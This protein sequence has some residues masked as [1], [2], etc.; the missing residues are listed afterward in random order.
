VFKLT[1]ASSEE[2]VASP[3][4]RSRSKRN[5]SVGEGAFPWSGAISAFAA[6]DR[7]SV[8][9][10]TPSPSS[11]ESMMSSLIEE[12]QQSKDG[13]SY[14]Q[15]RKGAKIVNASKRRARHGDNHRPRPRDR[16]LI[17]D[18]VKELRELVP[19]GAKCSIDGLL[20]L[21]IK[22]MLFLRSVT[23]QAD[24][25]RQWD[26]QETTG[27]KSVKSSESKGGH[28]NGTSWAFELG[29]ELQVC[30]IVVEDLEC[31]G[32]ML[33]EMLCND[34]GFFLEIADVIHRLDLNILKGVMKTRSDKTWAHFV[35]E[36][37]KGFHRLDIFWPLM[38]LMQRN[39]CSIP[40]KI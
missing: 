13:Y 20:D 7:N 8:T 33:I 35:V 34:H 30:P 28:Q 10:S 39:Q 32:H 19:D 26:H 37:S 6:R 9:N 15:S 18:R 16:Q 5:A 14:V 38:Q 4:A 29:S 3:V 12:Q 23:D 25:L 2:F 11:F 31:P 1:V 27:E 17:Q 40:S 24:K 22:H 36:A 21:T